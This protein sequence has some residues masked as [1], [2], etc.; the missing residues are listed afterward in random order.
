[1]AKLAEIYGYENPVFSPLRD[2]ARGVIEAYQNAARFL[3]TVQERVYIRMGLVHTARMIHDLAHEMPRRFDDFADMLHEKHLEAEY[4]GTPELD[5]EIPDMDR[6]F[7]IVTG[8][9]EDIQTA[10][11]GFRAVTDN[12][13]FRPMALKTEEL[14]LRNS[15]DHTRIL[16]AWA[17]WD[18]GAGTS[19]FDNWVRRL[20]EE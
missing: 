7:E 15:E 14:M 8:V 11:E 12:A 16:E 3:D 1:M 19:S 18:S 13:V 6:A 2:P 17:M 4:P 10:L 5:E 20:K 9:L